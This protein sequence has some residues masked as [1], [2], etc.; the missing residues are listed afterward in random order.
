MARMIQRDFP[1]NWRGLT[2]VELP[3]RVD[4]QPTAPL[5]VLVTLNVS[6]LAL[7]VVAAGFIGKRGLDRRVVA[8][9]DFGLRLRLIVCRVLSFVLELP[10]LFFLGLLSAVGHG[11]LL[12][13][14]LLG[15]SF[16][17]ES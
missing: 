15:L 17:V 13:L 16:A 10:S 6:R 7:P 1:W 11:L 9:I 4:M 12:G 14:R 5:I 3:L 8:E 2:V